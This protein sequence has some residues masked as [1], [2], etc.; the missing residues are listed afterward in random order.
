MPRRSG[1]FTSS[2]TANATAHDPVRPAS[3]TPRRASE[4]PRRA[5]SGQWPACAVADPE[6]D[7]GPGGDKIDQVL[8]ETT[9]QPAAA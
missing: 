5:T 9:S 8:V 3:S 2:E 6:R 1:V 7:P 4:I